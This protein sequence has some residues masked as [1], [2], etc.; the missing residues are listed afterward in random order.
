MPKMSSR[1]RKGKPELRVSPQTIWAAKYIAKVVRNEMEDF[2]AEYLSDAQMKEL[3]PLIRNAIC[4]ALHTLDIQ[5]WSLA[6]K[7]YVYL[8]SIVPDYC[9]Q[10]ELTK[11]FR[12]VVKYF[13]KHGE[14]GFV[15]FEKMKG[16]GIVVKVRGEDPD[17]SSE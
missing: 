7:Q 1:G 16:G 10:P 13:E 2:H 8:N 14:E 4:T 6:A 17:H 3:N 5:A 15:T 12:G 9:E 11:D